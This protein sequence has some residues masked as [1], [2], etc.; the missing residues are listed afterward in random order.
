MLDYSHDKFGST[1]ENYWMARIGKDSAQR[2]AVSPALHADRVAAPVLLLHSE[3]DI[4][5][6]IK[7]SEIMAAAL[8]KAGKK[9]EFVRIPGDDHYMALEQTRL[10][11][12]QE[13]EKFLAANIGS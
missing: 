13:V 2:D 6:P 7:Q 4:T 1:A 10:R 9:V 5:V 12:L 11:V 3:L 8:Q